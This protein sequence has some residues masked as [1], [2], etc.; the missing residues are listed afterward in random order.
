MVAVRWKADESLDAAVLT[1]CELSANL[2]KFEV[3]ICLRAR[4]GSFCSMTSG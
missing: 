3:R 4:D 2:Y 1:V